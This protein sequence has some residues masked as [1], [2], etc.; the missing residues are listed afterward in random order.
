MSL[1]TEKLHRLRAK[2]FDKLYEQHKAK[3]VEMVQNAVQFAKTYL[4]AEGILKGDLV[5]VL[6]TSI[7]VDKDFEKHTM[8]FPQKYWVLFFA[9]FIVEQVY[10]QDEVK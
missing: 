6:Q 8:T 10:P 5:A 1:D 2:D 4:K 7:R 3:W 9:E